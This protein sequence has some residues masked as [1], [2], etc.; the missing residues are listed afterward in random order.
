MDM[1][2]RIDH[3]REEI[4]KTIRACG[5]TDT[6]DLMAVSKTRPIQAVLEAVEAGQT[7]FGENRVQEIMQK[8]PVERKGYAV[9]LIGHLQSNKVRKAVG[10]VDAI[11]SIDSARIA[12]LVNEEAVRLGRRM[13]VLL[14]WNTSGEPAKSGFT[15]TNDFFSFLDAAED[16]A[17]LDIRGLMTVGPLNGDERTVRS[18]FARL[19][20]IR[21]ES[22]RRHPRLS[23]GTLSMG[24]SRDFSWAIMEG[25][26]MVRIGTAIF[27]G[28]EC[29]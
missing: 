5:R 2:R 18:A 4:E 12:A 23:F 7:L 3:V 29:V 26:T 21:T 11:D 6:V 14:E 15:D 13:P 19:R 22:S 20:E 1:L 10:A 24:M 28:R 25:S 27:G 16:M 17:G 8:F 9:H